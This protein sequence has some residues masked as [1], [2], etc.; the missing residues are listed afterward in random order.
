MADTPGSRRAYDQYS[1]KNMDAVVAYVEY[2][3]RRYGRSLAHFGPLRSYGLPAHHV[4]LDFYDH[5]YEPGAYTI[6]TASISP[7]GTARTATLE[8]G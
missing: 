2:V 5:F 1:Q 7:A 3:Y 4:D 6:F 8:A